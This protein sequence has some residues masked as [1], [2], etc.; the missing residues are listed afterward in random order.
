MV[1][2]TR[3][4]KVRIQVADQRKEKEN[5]DIAVKKQNKQHKQIQTTSLINT[6][7]QTTVKA[8]NVSSQWEYG[9]I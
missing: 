1:G 4:Y 8:D 9:I 3:G 5:E 7:L 2:N 6:A